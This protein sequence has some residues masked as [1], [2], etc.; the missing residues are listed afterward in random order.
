MPKQAEYHLLPV[1]HDMR[2]CVWDAQ[3][4]HH[5]SQPVFP[6]IM[7]LRNCSLIDILSVDGKASEIGVKQCIVSLTSCEPLVIEHV[8]SKILLTAW[9]HKM[10]SHC[11]ASQSTHCY[12]LLSI[13]SSDNFTEHVQ[14][15]PLAIDNGGSL[16]VNM[17]H[18]SRTVF[19]MNH[20]LEAYNYCDDI[21][22]VIYAIKYICS[23]IRL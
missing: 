7:L 6:L 12:N 23:K 8:I 21:P 14:C 13:Y 2:L 15:S 16:I 18:H 19:V 5:Y 9:G 10:R 17:Q 11:A 1:G 3:Q 4:L 20:C 22:I